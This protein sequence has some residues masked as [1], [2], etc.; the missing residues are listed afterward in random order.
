MSGVTRAIGTLVGAAMVIS[1]LAMPA[2]SQ[3]GLHNRP[4][5]GGYDPTPPGGKTQKVEWIFPQTR[6][7]LSWTAYRDADFKHLDKTYLL[8]MQRAKRAGV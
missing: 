1:S 7:L 3:L 6:I 8:Y 5:N 4:G 2:Y